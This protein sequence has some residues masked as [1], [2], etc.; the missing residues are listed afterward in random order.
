MSE[1][2][3]TQ[4]TLHNGKIIEMR[5]ELFDLGEGYWEKGEIRFWEN[6]KK[7]SG[8]FE[9]KC[10]AYTDS[11]FLLSSMDSPYPR[12]GLGE[13][14]LRFFKK[15]MNGAYIWTRPRDGIKHDDGSH[16]TDKAYIFVPKM[17]GLGLIEPWPD[18]RWAENDDY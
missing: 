2:E 18:S 11:R 9:F 7:L 6:G 3:I 14:A 15:I 10:D 16:L 12:M 1:T 5:L 17:Q 8:G 13:H 4:V